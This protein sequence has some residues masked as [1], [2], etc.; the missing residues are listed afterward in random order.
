M[1]RRS[2]N[3]PINAV[4]D[5]NTL[6]QAA[7]NRNNP[8]SAC[9]RLVESGIVRLFVSRNTLD[10]LYDVL[11]RDY[12]RTAFQYDDAV[13]AEFVGKVRSVSVFVENV[14]ARISLARDV[15]DEEYLNL[16]IEAKADFILTRDN[17]LLDLMTDHD[18]FSKEFRQKTRPLRI[19]EPQTFV[20][21]IERKLL[22]RLSMR[23]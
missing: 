3:F 5:C 20:K 17:D 22:D 4:F 1:R 18:V 8:S 15:D 13:V 9:F 12:I 23:P 21:I 7:A 14:P 6:L 19:V 16:A 2:S 10:E 11:N